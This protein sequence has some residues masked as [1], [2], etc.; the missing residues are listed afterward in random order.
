[1]PQMAEGLKLNLFMGGGRAA[2]RGIIRPQTTGVIFC[3]FMLA[4]KKKL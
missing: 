2:S 3:Y 4:I 1:M